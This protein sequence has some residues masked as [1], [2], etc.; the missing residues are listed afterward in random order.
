[1]ITVKFFLTEGVIRGFTARGHAESS[2]NGKFDLV[3]ADVSS[4]TYMTVNTLTDVLKVT[5]EPL[6]KNGFMEMILNAEDAERS[7]ELLKGYELHIRA[8]S[9]KYPQYIKVIYGGNSDA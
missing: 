1:M 6:V 3:C 9:K 8:L 2:R 4:A 7:K 5:A